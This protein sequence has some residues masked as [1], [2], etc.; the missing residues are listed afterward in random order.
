[1]DFGV[2]DMT[3]YP[4]MVQFDHFGHL[5]SSL[6]RMVPILQNWPILN[7]SSVVLKEGYP[8]LD[9]LL[10]PSGDNGPS[11][12]IMDIMESPGRGSPCMFITCNSGINHTIPIERHRKSMDSRYLV[13]EG[14]SLGS[15]SLYIPS[16]ARAIGNSYR[17][18]PFWVEIGPFWPILGH[19]GPFL[20]HF[21]TR[22]RGNHC[23][24]GCFKNAKNSDLGKIHRESALSDS[25]VVQN[26]V[27]ILG[28]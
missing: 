2:L 6:D 26:G 24:F 10:G 11:L 16:R 15:G 13:L 19:F 25:G 8:L 23:V 1:M 12:D 28:V 21:V 27:I 7:I 3:G 18:T 9:P 4:K 20:T 14:G 5:W 22:L 17:M